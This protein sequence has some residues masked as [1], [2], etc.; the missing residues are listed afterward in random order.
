MKRCPICE[1][2]LPLERFSKSKTE[3][4]GLFS[5]CKQCHS[6]RRRGKTQRRNESPERAEQRRAHNREWHIK[7]R[8][9]STQRKREY[10]RDNRVKVN[11]R[12]RTY[13]A[14]KRAKKKRAMPP[15]AD[16][17]HIK[18]FYAEAVILTELTGIKHEVDHIIPLNG[19]G[20]CGLHIPANLRVVT[21]EFNRKKGNKLTLV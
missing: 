19:V 6:A 11:E 5:Y 18:R 1:Q 16:V 20:V 9:R 12:M 7:N 10:A 4:C 13:E 21:K 14:K 17:E 15:W 3:K 2:H 8:E